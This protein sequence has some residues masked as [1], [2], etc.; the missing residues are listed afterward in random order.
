MTGRLAGVGAHVCSC[1]VQSFL[2]SLLFLNLARVK[3]I[4]C[5][6][7]PTLPNEGVEGRLI[8]PFF[9]NN[10][11]LDVPDIVLPR[12]DSC[13]PVLLRH[14]HP[15]YGKELTIFAKHYQPYHIMCVTLRYY[16]VWR[17]RSCP[18]CVI[19]LFAVARWF[20]SVNSSKWSQD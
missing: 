10:Y 1:L 5:D 3:I 16:G 14:T 19:V 9:W 7:F 2:I 13:C 20:T 15:L 8:N 12:Y 17:V 18:T 4:K 6:I 11:F